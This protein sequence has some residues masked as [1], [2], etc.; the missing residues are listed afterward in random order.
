MSPLKSQSI[1]ANGFVFLHNL[2]VLLSDNFVV[3]SQPKNAGAN[4]N[5]NTIGVGDG[6][7]AKDLTIGNYCNVDLVY[8]RDTTKNHTKRQEAVTQA[9]AVTKV[10]SITDMDEWFQANHLYTQDDNLL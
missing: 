8:E 3:N 1:K 5:F 2:I 9:Q 4:G 10:P 6:F 7:H